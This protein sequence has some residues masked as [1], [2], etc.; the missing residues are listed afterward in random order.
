MEAAP[1]DFRFPTTNRTRHCFT[2]YIE[3][4]RYVAS[5]REGAPECQKFDY[6]ES[7]EWTWSYASSETQIMQ[8]PGTFAGLTSVIKTKDHCTI[9]HLLSGCWLDGFSATRRDKWCCLLCKLF[10]RFLK[11][12]EHLDWH[13]S[14]SH[15]IVWG[16]THG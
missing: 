9:K 14:D 8:A 15:Y 16:H 1:A 2:R 10:F 11:N 6:I 12:L 3:C 5:K 13:Y 4:H 7:K